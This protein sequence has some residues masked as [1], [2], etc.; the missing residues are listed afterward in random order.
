[1]HQQDGLLKIVSACI[2]CI[3]KKKKT[4][5]MYGTGVRERERERERERDR[6]R[7]GERETERYSLKH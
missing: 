7:E 3:E 1:M 4:D 5:F 2:P 6:E